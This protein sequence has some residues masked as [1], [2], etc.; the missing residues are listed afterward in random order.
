MQII[1]HNSQKCKYTRK[2]LDLIEYKYDSFYD[3]YVTDMKL[4]SPNGSKSIPIT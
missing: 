1:N 3:S 4:A 2:N